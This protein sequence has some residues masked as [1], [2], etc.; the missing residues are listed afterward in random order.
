VSVQL[1][2]DQIVALCHVICDAAAPPVSE[3]DP[4]MSMEHTAERLIDWERDSEY[5]DEQVY[6]AIGSTSSADGRQAGF[7]ISI[8]LSR[9]PESD[10]TEAVFCAYELLKRGPNRAPAHGVVIVEFFT[11]GPW[12]D[13][14]VTV[15]RR[16]FPLLQGRMSDKGDLDA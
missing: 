14:L 5:K 7:E 6:I 10:E 13:H 15:E 16:A 9:Q 4:A 2:A 11:P 12:V 1:T 3:I 8:G